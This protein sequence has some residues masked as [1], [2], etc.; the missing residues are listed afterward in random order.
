MMRDEIKLYENVLERIFLLNLS[1]DMSEYF[2]LFNDL[3]DA[4]THDSKCEKDF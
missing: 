2:T 3:F 4:H 1:P